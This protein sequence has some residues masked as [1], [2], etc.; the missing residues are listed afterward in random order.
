MCGTSQRCRGPCLRVGACHA[1]EWALKPASHTCL[2]AG[3]GRWFDEIGADLAQVSCRELDHVPFAQCDGAAQG[4]EIRCRVRIFGAEGRAQGLQRGQ[5]LGGVHGRKGCCQSPPV[6]L[7]HCEPVIA[8][9]R[10]VR[11]Q[12]HIAELLHREAARF[13]AEHRA[14]QR[15]AL[16]Q[17]AHAYRNGPDALVRGRGCAIGRLADRDVEVPSAACCLDAYQRKTRLVQKCLHG[18]DHIRLFRCCGEGGKEIVRIGC[19]VREAAHVE[20]NTFTKHVGSQ[21]L[22]EHLQYGCALVVGQA[23]EGVE[24]VVIGHDRLADCAG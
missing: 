11:S 8:R 7:R 22:L 16:A 9:C 24:D 18:P 20:A 23:V 15:A 2:E 10:G 5:L 14:G 6:F 13:S 4:R 1:R 21:I 17:F 19:C 12:R 3:S